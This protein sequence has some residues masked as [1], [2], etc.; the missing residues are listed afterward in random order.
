MS[1]RRFTEHY[2][3]LRLF[4]GQLFG[5]DR[6]ALAVG[7][8]AL[9]IVVIL[10]LIQRA[11][12]LVA[13]YDDRGLV[14]RE[15]V[16][17]N[18]TG[19]YDISLH[20]MSGGWPFEAVLFIVAG[21]FA[22]L[23]LV[24]YKTRLATIITWLLLL[25][26]YNR[27]P[28]V[29]QAGDTLLRMSFFWGMWLPWGEALSVDAA[30]K[31]AKKLPTVVTSVATA[32]ILIQVAL[33]YAG[34]GI[35]KS[36]DVWLNQGNALYL[37]FNL[38]GFATMLGTWLLQWPTFLTILSR[39]SYLLEL[40]GPLLIFWPFGTKYVRLALVAAYA[41]F[42][43]GIATTLKIGLFAWTDLAVLIFFLPPI[44]WATVARYLQRIS[45]QQIQ[46]FY[47]SDCG[48]CRKI[49][50][51]IHMFILP[52]NLTSTPAADNPVATQIMNQYNSWVIFDAKKKPHTGYNGVCVVAAASPFTRWLAPLLSRPWLRQR[53]E[54]VYVWI[55]HRRQLT[56]TPEFSSPSTAS[57]APY[58]SFLA[59]GLAAFF[60]IYIIAW[61]IAAYP[62][63]AWKVPARLHWIAY[64]THI[65]QHWGMFAPTPPREDGWYVIPGVLNNDLDVDV[66]TEKSPTTWT[67]PA[68]VSS[69]YFDQYWRK[70]LLMNALN[71]YPKA[72]PYY[73]RYLC[74]R[75]NA[76]HDSANQLQ[77]LSIYYA[78]E[79]TPA[80]PLD[81]AIPVEFRPLLL[82]HTCAPG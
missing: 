4:L 2:P 53:G 58:W 72:H 56:C 8:V 64:L 13:F 68:S 10:D 51:L 52:Y 49:V 35:H 77:Q 40:Y 43:L 47:D 16:I 73:A 78:F 7:R 5:I 26:L 46:I 25:S 31:P 76:N 41:L 57:P 55:A 45:H 3:A 30:F 1:S 66:F 71:H 61:N 81:P 50:R 69:T 19:P 36:A 22:L 60:L 33:V 27:N 70:Y 37:T 82:N 14:P 74:T 59:Q 23:V 65:D 9:A 80:K 63:V 62:G 79:L 18:F 20:M 39:G 67:K 48:M 15:Y 28:L 42:H 34:G 17:S 32:A 6:R 44:L 38:D 24:G 12:S 75:W 11:R 21:F 54:R 29:T